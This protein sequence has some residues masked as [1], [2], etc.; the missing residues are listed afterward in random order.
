MN[1]TVAVIRKHWLPLMGLNI[2]VISATIF[3]ATVVVN[4][5]F[6]PTWTARAK[7]NMPSS[8]GNLSAD[9]GPLGNLGGGDPVFSKEVNA[10]EIQAAIL[11]SDK[12]IERVLERDR[13]RDLYPEIKINAYKSLFEVIPQ[14]QTT[15]VAVN[16]TASQPELALERATNWIDSYQQ[17]LSELRQQDVSTRENTTELEIARQNLLTA[18]SELS[19]F[20]QATGIVNSDTQ[21]QELISSLSELRNR[22]LLVKAQADAN[23]IKA[24]LMADNLGVTPQA[25]AGSLRLAGNI[26]Y[27]TVRERLAQ[28]ELEL[29]N[30]RGL[31]TENSP[32]VQTLL[33]QKAE[34]LQ[35]REAAINMAVPNMAKENIDFTLGNHGSDNRN[36]MITELL[37][38]ETAAKQLRQETAEIE[39]QIASRTN[40]LNAIS[41]NNA[42]LSQLQRQ[43][44]IAEGVY[45]GIVAQTN[46]AKIDTFN[47][48]PNV[49][50]I[51]GPTLN[52]KPTEPDRKLIVLGGLLA[53]AFGSIGL[54]LFL[55]SRDPLLS[56]KDLQ[57][58]QYPIIVGISR[59][60]TDLLTALLKNIKLNWSL[61]SEAENEFQRL[62][63]AFSFIQLENRRIAISSASPGEGKTTVTIGLALT[64]VKLGFRVLVVDGDIHRAELSNR[65]Q[66]SRQESTAIAEPIA[67]NSVAPGLSALAAPAL[68]RDASCKYF[69][70]GEFKQQLDAIQESGEYDYVL[71]DCAPVSVASEMASI[72]LAVRNFLFVVQPGKSGRHSVISSL[73]QLKQYDTQIKGLIINGVESQTEGYRYSQRGE[74]QEAKA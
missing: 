13:E 57:L 26:E 50:L 52:P 17:R 71:V 32:N 37:A 74:L 56:P 70:R 68:S 48:Y 28:L 43:Y 51:D 6:T 14:A 20:R 36:G 18:Q 49:Q 12:V 67:L 73:E 4:R 47:S 33:D 53:S 2:A 21:A 11:A 38:A 30:A 54:L 24:R 23:Q 58:V 35:Q 29:A 72:S 41:Q 62:A 45:K 10:L 15:T 44:E 7:L 3:A 64:L 60:Q 31:Y 59:H 40:E 9:L 27:Q 61:N 46:Q 16:V 66:L 55:E 8:G 25:A 5:T 42:Q 65:L 22:L 1:H 39:T 19:E 63:S 34:L 69:I